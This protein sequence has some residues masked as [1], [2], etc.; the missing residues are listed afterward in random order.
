VNIP[1]RKLAFQ[2]AVARLPGQR[3]RCTGNWCVPV[4]VIRKQEP[5]LF[6]LAITVALPLLDLPLCSSSLHRSLPLLDKTGSSPKTAL[7]L[8]L[9]HALQYPRPTDEIIYR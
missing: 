6:V 8:R 3:R 7:A 1:G 9:A 4:F 2:D 5:L